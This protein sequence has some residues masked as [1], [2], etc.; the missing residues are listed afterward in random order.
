MSVQHRSKNTKNPV[1]IIQKHKVYPA[2]YHKLILMLKRFNLKLP[3]IT[4]LDWLQFISRL[5]LIK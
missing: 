1:L 2:K 3:G 4:V 5:I